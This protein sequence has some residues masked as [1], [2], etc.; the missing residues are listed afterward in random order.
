V[1]PSLLESGGLADR[2][3]VDG[4]FW[5]RGI[6]ADLRSFMLAIPSDHVGTIDHSKTSILFPR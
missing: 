2:T 6:F 4:G 3:S 5:A 1:Q